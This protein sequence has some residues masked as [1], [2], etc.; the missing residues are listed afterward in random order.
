MEFGAHYVRDKAIN[1]GYINVTDQTSVKDT[2]VSTN[3]ML[4]SHINPAQN[5]L[6]GTQSY[7]QITHLC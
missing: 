5:M 7:I 2:T 3:S 1:P 6:Y 4:I